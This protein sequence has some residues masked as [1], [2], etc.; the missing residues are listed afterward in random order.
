MKKDGKEREPMIH[1]PAAYREKMEKQLGTEYG[2]YE[3]SLL[4]TARNGL[5]VNVRKV[6]SEAYEA[7]APFPLERVPWVKNGFYYEDACAPAKHPHYYAGLYYLQEP[8]AMTPASRL[9]VKPGDRVLDLCAAPGGKA[10]ELGARLEGRGFLLANDLSNSRAKALLKNLEMAGIPNLFVTSEE[11]EK[12]CRCYPAFF[13]KI[14]LDAPCSGEGMFRR[15][16]RMIR[17]WEERGPQAYVPVQRALIRQAVSMLRP[18]GMLL[19]ST[20]TFSAEENEEIVLGALREYPELELLPMEGYEGF[21]EGYALE[22]CGALRKCV[23]IYPHRMGGEGHFL[24]LLGK[25]G[26]EAGGCPEA[27]ADAGEKYGSERNGAGCEA[28]SFR[29]GPGS[30]GRKNGGRT[31]LGRNAA[32]GRAGGRGKAAGRGKGFG[33]EEAYDGDAL[34]EAAAE[35]LAHVQRSWSGGRFYRQKD[36]LYYLADGMEPMPGLRY[37]RTGLHLGK[38]MKN[39]FEPSQALAMALSKE[40]FDS[41]IDLPSSDGRVIRYLKGETLDISDCAEET[42]EGWRLFCTDGWPLGFGKRSGAYMKNKYYA[43]WRWQ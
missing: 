20:C 22:G 21:A 19:Y 8:S 33:R 40:E 38:I 6:S 27:C 35:F 4:Q 23:H 17:H 29:N 37:L 26:G 28:G 31:G 7:R 16:P 41:V 2:A 42:A 24:A 11:P 14:L 30:A 12:L 18:G 3:E 34:P 36:Q 39:R 10:T 5:R 43:G 32:P 15:E 1:L 25:K 13:D 9:P